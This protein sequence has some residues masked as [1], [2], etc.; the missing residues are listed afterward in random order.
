MKIL[1]L[2]IIAIT[3]NAY[4]IV[5]SWNWLLIPLMSAPKLTVHAAIA[6]SFIGRIITTMHFY[7]ARKE[8][9][10]TML[11]IGIGAPA[12]CIVIA[13]IWSLFL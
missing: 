11:V 1:L 5:L 4:A 8:S 12:V 13:Y 7:D 2:S 10:G 9:V 6:V 3:L